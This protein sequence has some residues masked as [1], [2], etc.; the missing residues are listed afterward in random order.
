MGLTVA[1]LVPLCCWLALSAPAAA[2]LLPQA[3]VGFVPDAP[4][5]AALALAGGAAQTAQRLTRGPDYLEVYSRGY[6]RFEI[7]DEHIIAYYTGGVQFRY[8][9]YMLSA[10]EVRFDQELRQASVTGDVQLSSDELLLSSQSI[11][12]D[13]QAGTGEVNGH[14]VGSLPRVGVGF[15]ATR[16]E[17][18]FPPGQDQPALDQTTLAISDVQLYDS[19]GRRLTTPSLTLQGRDL[20]FT[21][22]PLMLTG[23]VPNPARAVPAPTAELEPIEGTEIG[24]EVAA[25]AVP[26][27]PTEVPAR[28]TASA[29]HGRL[30]DVGELSQVQLDDLRIDSPQARVSAAAARALPL[31]ERD[32]WRIELLGPVLLN[33]ET[34]GRSI[35]AEAAGAWAELDGAG[36]AGVQ[37]DDAVALADGNRI[38]I[39]SLSLNRVGSRLA[40]GAGGGVRL[41]LNLAQLLSIE[42]L[43]VSELLAGER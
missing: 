3:E 10:E 30:T 34:G 25:P 32:A 6:S 27:A 22:G 5:V 26:A 18:A 28:V 20:T 36:L 38:A 8:L 35:I 2:Q 13:G 33:L 4:E 24:A 7:E 23:N 42:P 12:L 43:D 29:L 21:T 39:G 31:A 11:T 17:L 37:L 15:E 19:A 40:L 1:K 9:G 41:G 14:V 16:V